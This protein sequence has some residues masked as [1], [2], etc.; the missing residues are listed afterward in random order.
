MR[1]GSSGRRE[2][3]RRSAL[4]DS[5]LSRPPI[6]AWCGRG[7]ASRSPPHLA[8]PPP[9]GR[10]PRPSPHRA[11]NPGW[12]IRARTPTLFLGLASPRARRARSFC[13]GVAPAVGA[14]RRRLDAR[15]GTMDASRGSRHEVTA[16]APGSHAPRSVAEGQ[17]APQHSHVECHTSHSS[18]CS[19]LRRSG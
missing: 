4:P 5:T 13:A 11:R 7:C 18:P 17:P 1:R 12:P 9:R 3:K 6:I 10:T 2:R 16:A 8:R 19:L 14:A 15:L